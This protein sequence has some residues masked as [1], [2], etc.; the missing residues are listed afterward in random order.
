MPETQ[1]KL[2][3]PII[4]A[5]RKNLVFLTVCLEDCKSPQIKVESDRLFFKGVGGTD[6]KEYEMNLELFDQ[7]NP[8]ESKYAV[9]DRVVE[10]ILIK[11]SSG[12]PFWKRLLKDDRRFHW[13][14]VDFDKWRDE[15]ESDDDLGADQGDFSDMMRQMGGLGM[16][17]DKANLNDMNLD[18]DE[19]ADSDDEELPGL[20]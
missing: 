15:D 4:W 10:F 13:L 2:S 5:Q 11:A 20:E 19:E 1:S 6:H 3:P 12:G 8:Q 18:M 17:D 9:R 16:G 7:I 14:K